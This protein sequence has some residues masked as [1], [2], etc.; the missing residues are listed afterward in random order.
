M[1][2]EEIVIDL[3]GK[4]TNIELYEPVSRGQYFPRYFHTDNCKFLDVGSINTMLQKEA[5][6]WEIM[7]EDEYNNTIM[8]NSEERAKFDDWFGSKEAKVLCIMIK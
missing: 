6:L 7:T 2:I 5:V 3:K 1:T 8:A 4:Y